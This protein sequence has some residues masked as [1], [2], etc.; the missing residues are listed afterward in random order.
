MGRLARIARLRAWTHIA[1]FRA[2]AC[3]F[4]LAAALACGAARANSVFTVADVPIDAE[5]ASAAEARELA[6]ADG[7]RAALEVLL[8]RLTVAGTALPAP[9]ADATVGM[10]VGFAI[11]DELVAPTRYR[12]ALTVDFDPARV[13]ALL[14]GG[15]VP[16]AETVSK[17]VLIV[18]VQRD[19]G[20]VLLWED[21]NR[22]R[23]AWEERALHAGLVPFLLPLGDVIDLGMIDGE[24]ALAGDA[25]A[26]AALAALYGTSEVVVAVAGIGGAAAVAKPAAPAAGSANGEASAAGRALTL[27]IGRSGNGGTQ[28]I[29]RTLIGR[30]GESERAL[31]RRA[32]ERIVS[33]IEDDWKA[34]NLIRY[35]EEH[36]LQA[37]VPIA[38]LGEWVSVQ[39]RLGDLAMVAAF[40][41]DSL[42]RSAG[43]LTLRYHGTAEQLRLALDQADLVLAPGE[44]GWLL[45]PRPPE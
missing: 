36:A 3:V 25:K 34:A 10:I 39:Q 22:W 38:S 24:R 43:R 19:A 13:R 44:D 12:A 28:A 9:E 35:D 45:H 20:G 37:A 30:E 27:R 6:I 7:Q 42:S 26:L 14:R 15:G 17:P 5:A 8:R 2:L 32:I 18:A 11:E 40:R 16:Y 23:Q 1:R 29:E 4:V 41:I 21:E 33:L 31:F